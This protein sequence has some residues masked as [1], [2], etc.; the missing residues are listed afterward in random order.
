MGESDT[1]VLNL[2]LALQPVVRAKVRDLLAQFR[3]GPFQEGGEQ[4]QREARLGRHVGAEPLVQGLD[5]IEARAEPLAPVVHAVDL[6]LELRE[7]LREPL[8][9][10]GASADLAEELREEVA[11]P[12]GQR[13]VELPDVVHALGSPHRNGDGLSPL[14]VIYRG[15]AG[16]VGG[17]RLATR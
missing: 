6:G 9:L 3:R 1:P 12:T 15:G 2:G 14:V 17:A 11:V 5:R 13:L 4:V 16:S 8:G 10:A 7:L